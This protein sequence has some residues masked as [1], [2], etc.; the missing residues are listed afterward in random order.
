MDRPTVREVSQKMVIKGLEAKVARLEAEILG[1]KAELKG[2][3]EH[4]N[5]TCYLLELEG[6]PNPKSL[7]A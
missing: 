2:A 6:L 3:R 4:L 7:K 5:I 1:L